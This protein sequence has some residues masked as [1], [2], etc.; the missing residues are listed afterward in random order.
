MT[1]Y[2]PHWPIRTVSFADPPAYAYPSDGE[3]CKVSSTLMAEGSRILGAEVEKSVLSRN[4]VILPGAK[5]EECIIGQG[6][7]IGRNC[8]LRR[9]IVD[10]HNEIP[11]GTVLGYDLEEDGKQNTVDESSGIVVVPMPQMQLRKKPDSVKET[12]EWMSF[13]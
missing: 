2:N 11:N 13:S 5:V 12:G 10:G 7:I 4:C 9:V 1:L 8:R 3:S 6:V